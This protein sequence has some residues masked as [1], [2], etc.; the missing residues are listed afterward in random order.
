[1]TTKNKILLKIKWTIFFFLFLFA[2][3][4]IPGVHTYFMVAI[5]AIG[6]I[7]F[8]YG[9]KYKNILHMSGLYQWIVKMM[10]F[11]VYVYAVYAI[12][13]IFLQEEVQTSHYITL[14]NRF[15]GL[16]ISI[17]PVVCFVLLEF[18]NYNLNF[19]Y[20]I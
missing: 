11:F 3:P 17:V 18:E 14:F 20:M 16:I 19:I 15:F 7:L 12:N 13:L 4:I 9:R 5:V 6:M 8:K 10:I 2:P 1:M